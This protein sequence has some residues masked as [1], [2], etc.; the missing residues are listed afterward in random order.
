MKSY[1]AVVL[2]LVCCASG[3]GKSNKADN[4]NIQSPSDQP[5]GAPKAI[6]SGGAP[7]QLTGPNAKPGKGNG[8]KP[9]PQIEIKP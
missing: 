7:V 8:G 9:L 2:A 4:S 1:L 6:G 5:I 3:C